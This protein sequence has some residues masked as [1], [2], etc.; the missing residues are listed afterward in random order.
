MEKTKSMKIVSIKKF[1]DLINA[2]DKISKPILYFEDSNSVLFYI[3]DDR[4]CYM[5]SMSVKDFE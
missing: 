4:V 5:Y 2:A 3:Y 1:D